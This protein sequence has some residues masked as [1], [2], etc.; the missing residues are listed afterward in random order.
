MNFSRGLLLNILDTVLGLISS[1]NIPPNIAKKKRNPVRII[2]IG[3]NIKFN[4]VR[5]IIA[6]LPD[7][8]TI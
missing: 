2:T 8:V 5:V 3:R 4:I 7:G 1:I 6:F